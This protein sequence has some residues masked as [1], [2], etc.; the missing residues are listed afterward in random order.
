MKRMVRY[1]VKADRV[2][3]NERYIRQVYEELQKLAPPG[4]R[5]AT[6]RLA[7][8]LSFMHIVTHDSEEHRQALLTLPAF[9]AFAAGV[10]ERC[11][12]P[13]VTVELTEIGSYGF[14]ES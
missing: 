3:E 4:L 2:E 8:G 5:Y 10:G 6:F 1:K 14:F 7:D 11:E 12:E 9:K 13:A